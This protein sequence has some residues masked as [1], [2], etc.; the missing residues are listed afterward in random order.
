MNTSGQDRMSGLPV[1]LKRDILDHVEDFPISMDDA[2][3][4]SLE[5]MDERKAFVEAHDEVGSYWNFNLC[6][7]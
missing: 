5:L 3:A 1:R 4:L 7:H 6:E 2:K